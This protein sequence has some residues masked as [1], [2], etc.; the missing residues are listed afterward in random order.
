MGTYELDQQEKAPSY[1]NN[2]AQWFFML[3][4]E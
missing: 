2:Q 4:T 1:R 3:R